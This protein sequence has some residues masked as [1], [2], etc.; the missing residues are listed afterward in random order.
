VLV[1]PGLGG[2]ADPEA[3]SRAA[4]DAALATGKAGQHGAY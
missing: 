3:G 4:L 1:D 2:P